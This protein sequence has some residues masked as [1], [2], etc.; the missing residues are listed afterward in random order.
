MGIVSLPSQHQ[1]QVIPASRKTLNFEGRSP[2]KRPAPPTLVL[3]AREALFRQNRFLHPLGQ[4]AQ[5]QDDIFEE[6]LGLRL[7]LL[8]QFRLRREAFDK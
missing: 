8:Q 1:N 2:A 6:Y 5:L 7:A 4:L 3:Q